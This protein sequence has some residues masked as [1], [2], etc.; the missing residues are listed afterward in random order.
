MVKCQHC[1]KGFHEEKIQDHSEKCKKRD[2]EPEAIADRLKFVERLIKFVFRVLFPFGLGVK[3]VF[4]VAFL[5]PFYLNILESYFVTPITDASERVL[6]V[7]LGMRAL[8]VFMGLVD[9]DKKSPT[10]PKLAREMLSYLKNTT[11]RFIEEEEEDE[12][13]EAKNA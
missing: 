6:D 3:A 2:N 1:S 13:Y 12:D 5:W 8:Y 10:L 9:G 4:T 7:V 11:D